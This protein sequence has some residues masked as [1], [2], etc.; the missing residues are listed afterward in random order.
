KRIANS[1]CAA[2]KNYWEHNKAYWLK[3]QTVWTAY[4][5]THDTI[6]LKAKV[7][8]KFLYQYLFTL[9]D[10]Y[11]SKK[12]SDAEIDSRIKTEIIKFIE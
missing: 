3:V 10:D 6:K 8:G 2:A 12:V 4:M 9:L 5:N 11:N 1:E 7:D